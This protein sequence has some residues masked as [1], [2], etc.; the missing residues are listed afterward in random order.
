VRAM[1]G[2]HATAADFSTFQRRE[3]DGA[4]NDLA[5]LAGARMVS[6]VEPERGRPMAE[7]VVKQITGGDP[8]AARFLFKE[9]FEYPPVF[10]LWWAANQRQPI[11]GTD[12]GMWRRIR[13]VPFTVTIPEQ[14][15]DPT[16][17]QK[18]MAELPGILAWAVR[19]CLDWQKDG[20]GTPPEVREATEDY[21]DVMD[22]L[23]G[24]LAE[25]C[26]IEPGAVA[27]A[28]E[29]YSTYQRWAEANAEQPIHQRTFG[30][31]LAERG[32]QNCKGAKGLRLWRG[33]RLREAPTTVDRP[34][35][36]PPPAE[37]REDAWEEG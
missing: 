28:K 27:T 33:L 21:R 23:G 26:A 8:I 13:L 11:T 3:T 10:K 36:A 4:R 2:A 25:H 19:G 18:L 22:P 24:F 15:R 9:Y 7:S 1:R 34:L 5:R 29:L 6:A 14:E 20:L 35:P 17:K 32:L 30:A 12:Y 37:P 16:L 31:R